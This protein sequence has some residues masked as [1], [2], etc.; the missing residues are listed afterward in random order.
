MCAF[1]A[2]FSSRYIGGWRAL[3]LVGLKVNPQGGGMGGGGV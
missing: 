1:W 3:I 2:T